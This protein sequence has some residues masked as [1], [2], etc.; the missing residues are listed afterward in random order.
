M[1]PSPM[2]QL[3]VLWLAIIAVGF[4]GT[5]CT[6]VNIIEGRTQIHG[7]LR[8][9]PSNS[10]YFTDGTGRAVYLTGSHTWWNF[11]DGG[12]SDPPPNFDF[13]EYLD[14][15]KRYNHNFVRLWVMEQAR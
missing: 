8:V 7:P 10:R 14:F 9:L 15:L 4:G 2:L 6:S 12:R 3:R 13:I 11:Q 1:N 5:A